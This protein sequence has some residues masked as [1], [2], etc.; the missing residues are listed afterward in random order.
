MSAEKRESV[1]VAPDV[2]YEKRVVEVKHRFQDVLVSRISQLIWLVVTV[3]D[4]LLLT[5]MALRLIAADPA[6]GFVN[7]IYSST[8]VLTAPFLG[9]TAAPQ[10]GDGGIFDVAALVAILVYSFVAWVVVRLLAIVLSSSSGSRS[11]SKV[12]YLD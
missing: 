6:S 1:Q 9:I 2:G 11:V 10:I 7:F 3:G 4:V 8:N 12:E 5:R